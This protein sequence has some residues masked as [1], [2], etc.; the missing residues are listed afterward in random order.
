MV[1]FN[2]TRI[3]FSPI[4]RVYNLRLLLLA[5]GFNI[6]YLGFDL[7]GGLGLDGTI[8][9]FACSCLIF[10][11]HIIVVF[12]PCLAAVDFAFILIE[13]GGLGYSVA[14]TFSSIP[15][16][17]FLLSSA[18]LR[19]ATILKSRDEI[20][21]QRFAFLGGCVRAHPPYTPLAILLNRSLVR[22]LVRGESTHIILLRAVILSCIGVG[23]PL[24]GVY[25]VIL[26]PL[27][28]TV[29]TQSMGLANNMDSP[30]SGNTT[31]RLFALDEDGDFIS[32]IGNPEVSAILYENGT[33][34]ACSVILDGGPGLV[35]CPFLWND[36]STLSLSI[37]FPPGMRVVYISPTQGTIPEAAEEL[38]QQYLGWGTPIFRGLHLAG[39][40]TW[41]ERQLMLSPVSRVTISSAEI[42]GLQP[43]TFADTAD[44]NV[45]TLT[46]LQP[47]RYPTRVFRDTV[48]VTALS[49][50]ATFGGFW[51]FV[52]GA[53]ALFFGANVIYFAFGRRPLSAL[54]V[55][56]IFQRGSL[57]R[58]WNEDFPAIH[59]EG[60]APGSESAGIVAFIRQRLVD[61]D[62]DPRS[63]AEDDEPDIGTQNERTRLKLGK[64]EPYRVRESRDEDDTAKIKM[65]G[66]QSG[67]ESMQ[68]GYLLDEI[69]R[70]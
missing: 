42:T 15:P 35:L 69:P 39:V 31:I 63:F 16:L 14:Q 58:Q 3:L 20:P 48:D 21:S 17:V 37:P 10:I 67:V 43:Q 1:D 47:R 4:V 12:V 51:T 41:T 25:A 22:P 36:I 32:E 68:R 2:I 64:F 11:H 18:V 24:F 40:M 53:F 30:V 52:D 19:I 59:T 6:V 46:L 70:N 54:G 34:I 28:A 57:V 45:T 66:A 29:T 9:A 26:R 44:S 38:Y 33:S 8:A 65:S 13:A 27:Q 60:G 50:I 23:V 56:H 7:P 62:E 55:V 5:L 49:G 61:V